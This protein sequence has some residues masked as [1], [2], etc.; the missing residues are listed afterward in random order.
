MTVNVGPATIDL[1]TKY[2]AN[3]DTVIT[4]YKYNIRNG[5]LRKCYV[6]LLSIKCY[7]LAQTTRTGRALVNV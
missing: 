3:D 5:Y 4:V 6:A 2:Y 7:Y 1:L